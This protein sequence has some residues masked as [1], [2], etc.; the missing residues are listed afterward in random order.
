MTWLEFQSICG[1]YLIT[2]ELALENDNIKE[3]LQAR[4]DDKVKQ[5]LKSEF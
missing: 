1:E 3:A 4:D 5:L 2:P